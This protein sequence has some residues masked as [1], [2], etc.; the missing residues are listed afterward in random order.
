MPDHLYSTGLYIRHPAGIT[1]FVDRA[2][3]SLDKIFTTTAGQTLRTQIQLNQNTNGHRV[4]VQAG[5]VSLCRDGGQNARTA[6]TQAVLFGGTAAAIGAEIDACL[7]AT[8]HAGNHAWLATAINNAPIYDLLGAVVGAPSNLG[9][10]AND[11]TDWINNATWPVTAA[12]IVDPT[13]LERTLLTALW[14]GTFQRPGAGNS[15]LVEW[16]TGSLAITTTTGVH[17]QR[18]KSLGLAHEL[19]H[20]AHSGTGI[21]MGIDNGNASTALYEYMCVGLGIWNGQPFS[22]NA[23]R[24]QW[25]GVVSHRSFRRNVHYAAVAARPAY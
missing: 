21:Q 22:E 12:V 1:D 2:S 6:L 16:N 4:V 17:M 20:A 18:S 7:T 19:V 5:A 10:V 13:A 15:S 23:I 8:G 3:R 24:A 14:P 9:I 25:H 11:V